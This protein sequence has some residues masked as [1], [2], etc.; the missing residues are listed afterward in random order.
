MPDPNPYLRQSGLWFK[1]QLP[2]PAQLRV[3]EHLNEPGEPRVYAFV[4]NNKISASVSNNEHQAGWS[5]RV[6]HK[7]LAFSGFIERVATIK[8]RSTTIYVISEWGREAIAQYYAH[9]E[10]NECVPKLI[11]HILEERRK[12]VRS[13]RRL[14]AIHEN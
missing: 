11:A 12:S 6:D 1:S 13:K 4:S 14:C 2:T 5:V 10:M 9:K 7:Q 8:D 3:L